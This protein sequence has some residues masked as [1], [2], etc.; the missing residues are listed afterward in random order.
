MGDLSNFFKS[1]FDSRRPRKSN[2]PFL[3]ETIDLNSFPS[4]EVERWKSE[5]GFDAFA[6][7]L[8]SAYRSYYIIGKDQI[9]SQAVTIL[10]TSHSNGWFLQCNKLTY[11]D[12]EYKYF[13]NSLS[14]TLKG[15]G[16]IIQL[17][18]SKSLAAKEGIEMITHYYLKPSFRNRMSSSQRMT[19]QLF[20]NI[21]IEYIA[22][23]GIPKSFKFLA[24]SYNDS[25]YMA[26]LD[27]SDLNN[28]LFGN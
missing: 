6:E 3:H 8:N 24:K 19:S 20:G 5:G 27:F 12:S 13:A 17:A 15:L 16:Y 25:S 2:I 11:L 14:V 26:P 10:D 22:I 1:F 18:E 21:S 9:N 7:L 28:I 23:N 4:A